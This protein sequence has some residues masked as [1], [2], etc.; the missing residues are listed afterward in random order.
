MKNRIEMLRLLV[1]A[2]ALQPF[3]CSHQA[4]DDKNSI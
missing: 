4:I 3:L 1:I 2:A